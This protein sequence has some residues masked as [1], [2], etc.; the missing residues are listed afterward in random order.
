[1]AYRNKTFVSFASEDIHCYRMM[2]AWRQNAN[3]AFDFHDAHDLNTALDTSRPETIRRRL[4]QRFANTKQVVLLV[5]RDTRLVARRPSRFLYYEVEVIRRLG[6]PVVFA[7]L[8][9]SRRVNRERLPSKL[10]QPYTICVSFQPKIIR[11][12]LDRYVYSYAK[13]RHVRSGPHFYG[14]AIYEPL[15]L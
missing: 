14:K 7:H 13:H 9:G 11:F 4:R 1:M 12:A 6:L 15:G 5:S 3:I 8:D 2:Q 10:L